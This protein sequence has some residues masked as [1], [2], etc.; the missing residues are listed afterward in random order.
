MGNNKTGFSICFLDSTYKN[1][2]IYFS[3]GNI[4]LNKNDVFNSYS[5]YDISDSD[6]EILI[7]VIENM[8]NKLN[9]L[10]KHK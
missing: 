8:L 3:T 5:L 6:C 7:D 10:N 4:I 2:L 1:Q 9:N